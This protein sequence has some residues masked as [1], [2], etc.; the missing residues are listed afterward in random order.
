MCSL[1]DK[2]TALLF[3]NDTLASST[4]S[5]KDRLAW[6]ELSPHFISELEKGLAAGLTN[7]QSGMGE[8]F[9]FIFLYFLQ[10][11]TIVLGGAMSPGCCDGANG[12]MAS[13]EL[14]I[15]FGGTFVLW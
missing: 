9:Y 15:C 6:P 1:N 5:I 10:P 2:N 8:V 14:G 12:K 7:Y 13:V 11:I 4:F 3:I